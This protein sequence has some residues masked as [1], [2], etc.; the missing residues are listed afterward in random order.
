MQQIS[1]QETE[2]MKIIWDAADVRMTTRDI[3]A[4][5]SAIDGK[6]RNISSLM[7]VIARL[8]DKG[9]LNPVKKYRQSTYFEALI[10]ESE[11]KAYAT[12]QFIDGVH[13]GK[14]SSFVSALFDCGQYTQ[15]DIEELRSIL[16]QSREL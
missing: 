3:E 13:N 2:I 6:K 9:F 7:T 16:N 4:H 12:K 1:P 11:Y 10:Q 15:Q 14:L 5:L 8:V